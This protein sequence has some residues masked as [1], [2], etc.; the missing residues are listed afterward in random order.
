MSI[1]VDYRVGDRHGAMI[2]QCV[3]DAKST[4][5]WVRSNA[6]DLGINAERIVAAGSSAGGLLAA[7]T[8]TLPGHDDP[9][10]DQTISPIPN[11]QILFNPVVLM[12]ELPGKLSI[13]QSLSELTDGRMGAPARSLSPYHHV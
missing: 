5:R 8:A 3:S 7:A 6:D 11:A 2:S 9:R 1:A 10:D 12:E 13:P 4:M